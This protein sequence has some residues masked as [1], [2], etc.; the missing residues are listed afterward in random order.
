MQQ[1]IRQPSRDR[2]KLTEH[3]G[4]PPRDWWLRFKLD[5][6]LPR[7]SIN[8]R[9]LREPVFQRLVVNLQKSIRQAMAQTLDGEARVLLTHR[10]TLD[11][12]AFCLANG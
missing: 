7:I 8:E 6:K 2:A 1:V 5:S 11:P 3:I 10:G 4:I 12:L 9:G